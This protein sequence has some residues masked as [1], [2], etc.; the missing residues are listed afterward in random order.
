[1]KFLLDTHI[2]IWS[3]LSPERIASRVRRALADQRNELWISP[4]SVWEALLLLKNKRVKVVKGMDVVDNIVNT[5][6]TTKSGMGNVPIDP[7]LIKSAKR[8]D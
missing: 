6:T 8:I 3:V 2:L 1:M 7:I 5:Q 4:I